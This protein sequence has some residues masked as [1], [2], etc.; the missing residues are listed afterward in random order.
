MGVKSGR[1]V[2]LTTLPPS[3]SRLSRENMGASTSRK[4][5]GLRDLYRDNFT[6]IFTG[7]KDPYGC[8]TSRPP[9]L[10]DQGSANYGPGATPARRSFFCGPRAKNR[11]YI[12]KLLKM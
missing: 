8:E 7:H 1:R 6:F 10:L 4:P 5:K 12:S 3:M 11:F 2:G 9:Y